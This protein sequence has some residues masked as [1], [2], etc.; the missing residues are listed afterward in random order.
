MCKHR[1]NTVV[2]SVGDV[3]DGPAR[4]GDSLGVLHKQQAGKQSQRR[5][6]YLK[7]RRRLSAAQIRQ[8]PSSVTDRRQ[9]RLLRECASKLQQGGQRAVAQYH[10]STS[11]R[12]ARHISKCPRSLLADVFVGTGQE[13]D[14]DGHGTCINHKLCVITGSRGY[15]RQSPSCFELEGLHERKKTTA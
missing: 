14:K 8:R 1:L 7:R 13:T 11:H 5:L 10:I 15:V 3:A 2:G 6:D 4:V 9:A 12:V